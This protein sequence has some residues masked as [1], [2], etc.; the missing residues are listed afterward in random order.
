MA[1]YANENESTGLNNVNNVINLKLNPELGTEQNLGP[2]DLF[3][4]GINTDEID[5]V[6]K[7]Y[8]SVH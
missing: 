2:L 4:A 6:I 7:S 8:G 3:N 5:V 1:N